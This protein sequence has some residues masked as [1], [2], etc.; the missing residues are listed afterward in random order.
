MSRGMWNWC[1]KYTVVL[2]SSFN[3]VLA[4]VSSWGRQFSMGLYI[5]AGL[6]SPGTDCPLFL[7][8]KDVCIGNS[9]N[10][11]CLP[12]EQRADVPCGPV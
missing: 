12:P 6:A 2:A 1:S 4:A 5:F 9:W 10:I 3:Y 8:L 7:F 11:E